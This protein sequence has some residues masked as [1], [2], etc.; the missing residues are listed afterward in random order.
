MIRFLQL[1]LWPIHRNLLSAANVA[2]GDHADGVKSFAA[3]AALTET[4]SLVKIGTDVDHVTAAGNDEIPDGVAQSEMTALN[5]TD[6][7]RIAVKLLG[8]AKGTLLVRASAAID[9]TSVA[10]VCSAA[11]GR[12]KALPT[13][14]G[15]YYIVGKP[16]TAAAA[17]GDIIEIAPCV[18]TQRVVA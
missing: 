1:L 17:A 5:I 10:F 4:N 9:P 15:T 14:G 12:V 7:L 18:P 16:L 2:E 3:D 6:G 13:A 8:A 11:A